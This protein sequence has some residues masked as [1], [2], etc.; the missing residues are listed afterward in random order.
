MIPNYGNSFNVNKTD[1]PAGKVPVW[2]FVDELYPAGCTFND[3]AAGTQLPIGTPVSVSQMGAE[4]TVLETFEVVGAVAATDTS[5]VLKSVGGILNPAKDMI[6]G[7]AS[8]GTIAKAVKL[9]A[10][11][12]VGSGDHEGEYTFAITA[13]ALGVLSDGDILVMAGSTTAPAVQTPTGLLYEAV[14]V[15]NAGA[16]GT[17]VTKGQVLA[18]RIPD[19]PASIKAAIENRITLVN[20]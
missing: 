12:S 9:P 15:G 11:T 5:V 10:P 20:E 6:V 16:T 13:N 3:L 19:L 1:Y 7:K 2:L 4:A 18:K 17:V 8:S 14:I